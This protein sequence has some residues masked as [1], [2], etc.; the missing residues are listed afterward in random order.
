MKYPSGFALVVNQ[1]NKTFLTQ[2]N[3]TAFEILSLC[4]GTNTIDE[5]SF[6]MS[7]KY[8]VSFDEAYAN[9]REFIDFSIKVGTVNILA[10]SNF[11][12]LRILGSSEFWLPTVISIELT[13]RCPL[14]CKHCYRECSMKRTESISLSDIKKIATE[15]E[16]YGIHSVQLTGGEPL[17]H[18]NFENIIN[19]FVEKNISITILTSGYYLRKE[20]LEVFKKYARKI[21]SVQVSLDG[22]ESTHNTIRQKGNSYEKAVSLIKYL[23]EQEIQVDVSTSVMKQTREEIFELSKKLR[24]L[25]VSRH[26]LSVIMETGRSIQNNA[27]TFDREVIINNW[28]QEFDR[29]LSTDT[30]NVMLQEG[31]PAESGVDGNCGAGYKLLRIDPCMNIH[32]CIMIDLPLMNLKNNTILDYAVKYSN[33][34]D[35]VEPPNEEHCAGCP[36]ENKCKGCI[37]EAIINKFETDYCSWYENIGSTLLEL[38]TVETTN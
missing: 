32:P 12:E 6:K 8:K 21:G 11:N 9:V 13:Y 35:N 29:E 36:L 1:N 23:R 30:F 28:T 34:F 19:L 22:L 3:E 27:S 17:A 37:A 38:D 7:K 16:E 10:E 2:I 25:G 5:I 24:N 20:S 33:F 4:N 31:D 14:F 18:P 15:M 26:R